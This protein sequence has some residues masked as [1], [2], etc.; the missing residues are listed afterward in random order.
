MSEQYKAIVRRW[1][2]EGWNGGNFS[3]MQ[4]VFAPSYV[5]NI[6]SNPLRGPDALKEF[7]T[8]YRAAFRD[9]HVRI[10]DMVVEGDKVLWRFVASGTQTGPLTGIPPSGRKFSV[11]GMVLTR[12]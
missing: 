8:T 1:V 5:G 4:S 12:F 6:P 3:S 2:D 10:E 11:D 7:V 9:M